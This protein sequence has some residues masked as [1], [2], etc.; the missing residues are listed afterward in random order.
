[1][2]LLTRYVVW[3]LLKVFSITLAGMTVLM[4]VF[5][6]YKEAKDQGVGP[7]Q[8]VRLIPYLL[9]EMMRFTLPATSLFAVSNVYGRMSGSNEV[10]AIKSLGISP[11]A[12]V[13]PGLILAFLLSLG[14]VW[15]NELALTWGQKGAQRVVLEAVEEIVYGALRTQHS[16]SAKNIEIIVKAVEGPRLI[17]PTFTLRAK[18]DSA[19]MTITAEEAQLRSD[20]E[21]LR[22]SFRNGTVVEGQFSIQFD[23][24]DREIPL[25]DASRIGDNSR[26]PARVP[27]G[28]VPGERSRITS[29]LEMYERRRA[30][31][32]AFPL[33]TGEFEPLEQHDWPREKL[34]IQDWWNHLHR[35]A[36]EPPRRLSA[37]FSCLCFV[38][39]GAP[40]AI[41]RRNSDYM[42]NFFLCFAPILLVYYPLLMFGVE[43]AKSGAVHPYVVWLGNVVLAAWGGWLLKCRVLRY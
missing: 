41:W 29:E 25:F 1:M 37:A 10:L 16:Y 12:V 42:A 20:S 19:G 7:A 13:W 33:F 39:V 40:L 9:P 24:I 28:R 36:T 6:M 8:L 32:V 23:E 4:L 31:E 2:P 30:A 17:Q 21:V 38:L 5:G 14:T 18:G 15:L 34:I 27:L 22:V 43:Q 11:M 3:E 26:V 35:L